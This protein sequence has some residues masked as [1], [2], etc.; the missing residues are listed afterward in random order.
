MEWN[1]LLLTTYQCMGEILGSNLMAVDVMLCYVHM[2]VQDYSPCLPESVLLSRHAHLL[3]QYCFF[4]Y[5]VC[6]IDPLEFLQSFCPLLGDKINEITQNIR[7]ARYAAM[8]KY[9]CLTHTPCY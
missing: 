1:T 5:Y 9:S 7:F 3:L 4:V 2:A 8:F 6:N